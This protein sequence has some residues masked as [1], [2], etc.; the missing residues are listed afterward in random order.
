MGCTVEFTPVSVSAIEK[1]FEKGLFAIKEQ[2]LNDCNYYVRQYSGV[3]RSS[4]KSY[5]NGMDLTVEYD[6]SYAAKVYFTGTP[7]KAVNP[8]ASLQWC[9]KAQA[10]RGKVWE[11]IL[12]KGMNDG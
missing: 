12:Q 2:V 6:P 3:L 11:Q 7:S 9:H 10:A 4:G 5:V 1:R 8:N